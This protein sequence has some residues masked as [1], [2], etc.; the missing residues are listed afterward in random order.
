MLR[1]VWY[2]SDIIFP[3]FLFLHFNC[4]ILYMQKCQCAKL[5]HLSCLLLTHKHVMISQGFYSYGERPSWEERVYFDYASTSQSIT[6]GIRTGTQTAQDPGGRAGA[7][8][9]EEFCLLACSSIFSLPAFYRIQDHRTQGVPAHN[10]KT[11]F[12]PTKN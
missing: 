3:Y 8:I 9:I 10:G 5:E 7:D 1:D 6:K 11:P 2:W 12:Q 4:Y